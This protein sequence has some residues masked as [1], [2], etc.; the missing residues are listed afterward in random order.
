MFS[1]LLQVLEINFEYF[2]FRLAMKLWGVI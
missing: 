2:T 1:G